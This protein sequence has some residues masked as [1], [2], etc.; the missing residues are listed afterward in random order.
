MFRH[1]IVA[2]ALLSVAA[3]Q[4][5]DAAKGN[6]AK[7]AEA[8]K[9]DE[10]PKGDLDA[11][12]A[13]LEKRVDKIVAIL[14]QAMPPG[15]PD[16]A[17]TYSVPVYA[18][19]PTIGPADAKVT[20]IEGYEFLCPYC[21]KAAPTIDQLLADYPKDVRV[22]SKY[23][24][25]HGPPA[26]PSANAAC[27]AAKQG[28]YPAMKKALWGALFDAQ[29]QMKRDQA[30]A[31]A[32]EKIAA[33]VGL[34]MAKYKA[35][36]D[37]Q[38]CKD[39]LSK[40]QASLSAVGTTGTPSFYINGRHIGGALP[41]EEFKKVITEELAKADKAIAAGTKQADYYQKF[42]VE[43]GEKSVKGPFED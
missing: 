4:K 17:L 29:G 28:K 43:K 39:W 31:E 16:P 32:V 41:V 18:E 42:V 15:E 8:T 35:D 3:C 12:V 5:S 34:D 14:K 1:A 22:V 40:S 33:S 9:G 19:D 24:V 6:E 20:I 36:I 11:R 30:T 27:A 23:L 10:A 2:V 21:W 38:A 7:G 25:I 26:V 37:S 13:K